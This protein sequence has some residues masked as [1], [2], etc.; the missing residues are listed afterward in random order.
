MTYKCREMKISSL[1]PLL[2]AFLSIPHARAVDFG[3]LTTPG[4]F[5]SVVALARPVGNQFQIYCTGVVVHPRVVLTAAHCLQFTGTRPAQTEL[6]G[7]ARS[8]R[9]HT[10]SG[11]EGGFVSD[12]LTEIDNAFI[13]PRYLRDI[14]GQADIAV[15]TLKQPLRISPSP[16]VLDVVAL[17]QKLRP[18]TR[19]T[20]VGFGKSQ[21]LSGRLG[22]TVESFGSKREAQVR[23]MGK[24]ASELRVGP[25]EPVDRFGLY[26]PIARDGDSGGPLFLEAAD[27]S[28][29]LVGVVSRASV[30]RFDTSGVSYSLVRPWV[31]WAEEVTRLRIRE[32]SADIDFCDLKQVPPRHPARQLGLIE[33]CE[34]RATL[35]AALAYTVEVLQKLFPAASCRELALQLEQRPSINL[36]AT[37]LF[38]LSALAS[39]S[40]LE[41]LSLRDNYLTDIR[42]LE[43]LR[44]LRF[45]DLSYNLIRNNRAEIV[46]QA[47][48][49]GLARQYSEI[50]RTNFIRQCQS[51]ATSPEA[52]RTVDALLEVFGMQKSDCVNANYELIRSRALSFHGHSQLTDFSPLEGLSTLEALDI[53][54]T[55]AQDLS[56]LT[57]MQDLRELKL[58][59]LLHPDLTPV[60]HHRHLSTLSLRGTGVTDLGFLPQLPRLRTLDVRGNGPVDSSSADQRLRAGVLQILHD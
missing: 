4:N 36:D 40:Q 51:P 27:G 49:V 15:L 38:D 59:Q 23:V 30:T 13:H 24:T 18:N 44:K 3:Q 12:E 55:K 29:G 54:G 43:R 50:T 60:L 1:V 17:K 26:R 39:L 41:R 9:L 32:A 46:A 2:F 28:F 42:P 56:F 19:L 6:R 25:G 33:Q 20:I 14:R 53:S 57:R 10:G 21:Q 58:D 47:W 52:R 48:V 7:F 31:C 8:L 45:L 16:L 35:P 37:Y 34:Q 22:L 11:T 5:E